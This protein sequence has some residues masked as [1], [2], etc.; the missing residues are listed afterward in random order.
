[1]GVFADEVKRYG[2]VTIKEIQD[3]SRNWN[4]NSYVPF[5]ECFNIFFD[6][7]CMIGHHTKIFTGRFF[8]DRKCKTFTA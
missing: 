5:R 8:W 1:M 3:D 6:K 4:G 2:S 7:I